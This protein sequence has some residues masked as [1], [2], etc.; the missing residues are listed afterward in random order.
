MFRMG[1]FLHI[2]VYS[3]A[4]DVP[5]PISCRRVGGN[6]HS[7]NFD[8]VQNVCCMRTV[9][10]VTESENVTFFSYSRI[11]ISNYV[12]LAIKN[13]IHTSRSPRLCNM[14]EMVML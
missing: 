10:D 12:K 4:M 1:I 6:V 3:V 14:Y 8:T 9:G 7:R 2:Q 13:K 11:N 5:H